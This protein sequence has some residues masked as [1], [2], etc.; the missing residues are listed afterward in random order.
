MS[1][2]NIIIN[3][4][5]DTID[6]FISEI[7]TEFNLDRNYIKDI[8]TKRYSNLPENKDQKDTD[9][10]LNHGKLLNYL[11]TELVVLCKK[12]GVK[13]TGN[14]TQLIKNLLSRGG[15]VKK[16]KKVKKRNAKPKISSITKNLISDIPV[17]KLNRNRFGNHEHTDTSLVFDRISKKVIGKQNKDGTI[18]DLSS[19]DINVCKQYNFSYIISENFGDT[20]KLEEEF[21]YSSEEE[22]STNKDDDDGW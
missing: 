7:C 8:W 9:K 17:Y 6:A 2:N 5:N 14:K 22:T 20:S 18:N 12:R 4:V 10:E 3:S 16:V 1:L 19:E 15:A 21:I 11:K 13:C